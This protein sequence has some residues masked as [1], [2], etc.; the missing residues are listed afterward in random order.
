MNHENN[1][2]TKRL[3]IGITLIVLI[4][5][6]TIVFLVAY[7]NGQTTDSSSD[8]SNEDQSEEDTS[9]SDNNQG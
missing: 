5:T 7:Y 8:Q 4:I 1:K 6:G 2:D 3:I 9:S